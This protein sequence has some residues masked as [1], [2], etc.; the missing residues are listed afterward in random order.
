MKNEISKACRTHSE[1][2]NACKLLVSKSEGK[3]S[4]G[5]LLKLILRVI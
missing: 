2:R 1:L 4:A 5:I 3:G